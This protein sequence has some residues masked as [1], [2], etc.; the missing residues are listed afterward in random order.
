MVGFPTTVPAPESGLSTVVDMVGHLVP[1]ASVVL[2]ELLDPSE[3][4][5]GGER[6][7]GGTGSSPPSDWLVAEARS[8]LGRMREAAA[9]DGEIILS[10]H[11]LGGIVAKQ[12]RPCWCRGGRREVPGLGW[13]ECWVLPEVQERRRRCSL[14]F[15]PSHA[16]TPRY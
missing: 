13:R 2:H 9:G 11:G 5:D 4:D 8:L 16:I 10:G 6:G 1:N 7:G 15:A 3:R 12:V 14:W